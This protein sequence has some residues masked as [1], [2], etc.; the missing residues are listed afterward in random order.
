MTKSEALT[1]KRFSAYNAAIL[2]KACSNCE[3]YK[4]WFTYDRWQAQSEQVA[5]GQHG[6]KLAVILEIKK[7]D[8][9]GEEEIVTHPWTATVFCRHQ[10]T[11]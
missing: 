3:P 2:K 11:K 4:D 5:K 8:E 1:F 6:T 9:E 7:E 10:L